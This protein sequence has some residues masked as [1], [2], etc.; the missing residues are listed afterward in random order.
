[1]RTLITLMCAS[2][3]GAAA[4]A[5]DPAPQPQPEPAPAPV[6][7]PPKV[8]M[9]P[10]PVFQPPGG[11]EGGAREKMI[12][13]FQQV[14]QRLGEIDDLL[15]DAS[16]GT[17]LDAQAEAG[18]GDLLQRSIDG[19]EE[20]RRAMDEILVLAE[21]QGKS[22]S[23]GGGSP[24]SGD[25]PLDSEPQGPQGSKEET[26]EGPSQKPGGEQPAPPPGE[27][28]GGEGPPESPRDSLEAPQNNAAEDPQAGESGSA[29]GPQ[30]NERWGDLPT[31]VR[32]LFRTEG[33]GD[34]PPQYRDWIDAYY[35]RLNQRP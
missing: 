14:E 26:P 5:Q 34:L 20:V 1:M 31:H 29:S 12:E 7:E 28:P 10:L 23:Q 8:E 35:R 24:S 17:P 18:I 16:A 13:L 30:G 32:D 3:L 11:D 19:S 27:Q 9:P 15:F 22:Q 4:W 2:L 33:G 25:S 6:E 21:Q